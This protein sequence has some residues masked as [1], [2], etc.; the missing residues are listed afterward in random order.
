MIVS[1]ATARAALSSESRDELHRAIHTLRSTSASF[2]ARELSDLCREAEAIA[3][4]GDASTLVP[5]LDRIEAA[6]AAVRQALDAPFAAP[7]FP[8]EP[9]PRSAR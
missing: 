9:P 7:T 2:G 4:S 3:R 1:G 6:L 5:L 8:S